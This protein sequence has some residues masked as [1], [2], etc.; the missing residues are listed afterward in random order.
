M[1]N[2][3]TK[4]VSVELHME[5]ITKLIEVDKNIN[6]DE[7]KGW[8]FQQFII[9]HY[10]EQINDLGVW[11]EQI[12]PH[13]FDVYP[14]HKPEEFLYKTDSDGRFN[15]GFGDV[16][17]QGTKSVICCIPKFE[18]FLSSSKKETKKLWDKGDMKKLSKNFI[19]STIWNLPNTSENDSGIL[20]IIYDE[21][22]NPMVD[23][24]TYLKDVESYQ[25]RTVE[26]GTVLL[27]K[28]SKTL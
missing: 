1:E 4:V 16:V 22:D 12:E 10:Y 8:D 20:Q 27:S 19:T 25:K 9:D 21:K 3:E 18:V 2:L 6:I 13:Y 7:L 24:D 11:V 15:Y 17:P 14:N 26:I 5:P 23:V 28:G